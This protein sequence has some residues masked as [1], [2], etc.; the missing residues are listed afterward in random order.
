MSTTSAQVSGNREVLNHSPQGTEAGDDSRQPLSPITNNAAPTRGAAIRNG[1]LL[2]SGSTSLD[3]TA[4]K[5]SNH[6]TRPY[7]GYLEQPPQL[8]ADDQPQHGHQTR[9]R[10]HQ[11]PQQYVANAPEGFVD[12]GPLLTSGLTKNKAPR[13]HWLTGNLVPNGI[14]N[15]LSSPGLRGV[16]GNRSAELSD[17]GYTQHLENHQQYRGMQGRASAGSGRDVQVGQRLGQRYGIDASGL[18]VNGQSNQL[19][20]I[21]LRIPSSY[22]AFEHQDHQSGSAGIA[23][24]NAPQQT[25]DV[26]KYFHNPLASA[27]VAVARAAP[28]PIAPEPTTPA[29]TALALAEDEELAFFVRPKKPKKVV[30]A[31]NRSPAAFL[32]YRRLFRSA[33]EAIEHLRR[34]RD[35]GLLAVGPPQD[36]DEVEARHEDYVE[37]VYNAMTD[38]TSCMSGNNNTGYKR[39]I[40]TAHYDPE[41][42]EARCNEIVLKVVELYRSGGTSISKEHDSSGLYDEDY[43]CGIKKRI[44]NICMLLKVR[45]CIKAPE[46]HNSSNRF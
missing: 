10:P 17:P 13:N 18:Y 20:D 34:C 33:Q 24:N 2:P 44:R 26:G 22:N 37:M 45:I 4:Q 41:D 21:D 5:G 14:N 6:T 30:T 25:Y 36:V 7:E 43:G 11:R 40:K 8:A 23:A 27:P 38:R 35:R 28:E 3:R 19:S 42:M 15:T 1:L 31:K 12:L 9:V 46:N 29:R 39:W 16:F 32:P